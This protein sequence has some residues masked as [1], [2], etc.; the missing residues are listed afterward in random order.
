MSTKRDEPISAVSANCDGL[1]MAIKKPF[2]VLIERELLLENQE[3]RS[4]KKIRVLIGSPRWTRKGEEAR[5]PVAVEGWLGRVEDM[6]GDDPTHAMEMAL[7]FLNSLLKDLP[8]PKKLTWPNGDPYKG[9]YPD[10]IVVSDALF[11]RQV[12]LQ[13]EIISKLQ[14]QRLKGKKSRSK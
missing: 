14:R 11:R 1:N 3:T 13:D 12:K 10:S 7:Y 9:T 4:K 6:R 5:C 2:K 8:P